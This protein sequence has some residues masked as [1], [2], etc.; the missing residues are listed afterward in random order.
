MSLFNAFKVIPELNL[1]IFSWKGIVTIEAWM[2][3]KV[4]IVNHKDFR[5]NLKSLEDLR[6]VTFDVNMKDVK[7]YIDFALEFEKDN[8]KA[9]IL[10]STPNQV[11][12][13]SLFQNFIGVEFGDLSIFSTLDNTLNWL[14][15]PNKN[16]QLVIDTLEDLRN[17]LNSNP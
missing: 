6:E 15:I 14:D 3:Q 10:T 8:Q 16:K 13:S 11:A 2:K 1:I 12:I 7:K 5:L 17:E 4:N 9:A